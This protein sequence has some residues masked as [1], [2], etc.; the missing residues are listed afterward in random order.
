[1][2]GFTH[3]LSPQGY[4]V[5]TIKIHTYFLAGLTPIT[6]AMPFSTFPPIKAQR[7]NPV[8]G[9]VIPGLSTANRAK[10][11]PSRCKKACDVNSPCRG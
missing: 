2:L 11:C 10:K 8:S 1:M 3:F 5:P 7:E 6:S 9:Q 4:Y